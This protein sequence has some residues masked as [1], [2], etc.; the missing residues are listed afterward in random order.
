MC[1]TAV[2]GWT[3]S[4]V[5]TSI[6]NTAAPVKELDYPSVTTCRAM[7]YYQSSWEIPSLIF[8]ALKFT[9]AQNPNVLEVRKTFQPFVGNV[10]KHLMNSQ[11]VGQS[12]TLTVNGTVYPGTF[13]LPP[14]YNGIDDS[15]QLTFDVVYCSVAI[16]MEEE[17]ANDAYSMDNVIE[18]WTNKTVYGETYSIDDLA[19]QFNIE[20]EFEKFTFVDFFKVGECKCDYFTTMTFLAKLHYYP[21]VRSF[22]FDAFGTTMEQLGDEGWLWLM[23]RTSGWFPARD[24]ITGE[25]MTGQW[26]SVPHFL[27]WYFII[28][29]I[30]LY[31]FRSLTKKVIIV[32]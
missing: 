30:V 2:V 14:G 7:P 13:L 12:G 4:P 8:N 28:N 11:I 22:F 20:I 31:S 19:T 26:V 1:Y 9:D 25:Q 3:E 29:N 5:T 15:I 21:D 27:T 10:T 6:D 16:K 17:I 23:S 24:P 18:V 32:P